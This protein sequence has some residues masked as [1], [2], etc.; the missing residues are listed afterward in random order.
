MQQR[1][2]KLHL[3]HPTYPGKM[4][5]LLLDSREARE[6]L[7]TIFGVVHDAIRLVG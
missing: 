7:Y 5:P 3:L 1:K 2:Q 4:R 6:L